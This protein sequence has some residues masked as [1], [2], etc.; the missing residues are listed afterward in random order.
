MI[1]ALITLDATATRDL[2]EF[3][4]NHVR[5]FQVFA[6]L[7]GIGTFAS[8]GFVTWTVWFWRRRR[9]RREYRAMENPGVVVFE[10]HVLR[11]RGDGDIELDVVSWGGKHTL[12]QL[13]HDTILE[14]NIEKA[15]RHK[16][17]FLCL[18]QPGQLLMMEGLVEAITGNDSSANLDSLKGRA[19]NADEV[20][21]C[22]VTWK[23][24]RAAHLVRIVILDTAWLVKLTEPT[25]IKRIKAK[26]SRYQYRVEWL[27]Q[28]V[29]RWQ[30][31][32]GKPE[33][34]ACMRIVEITSQRIK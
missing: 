21:L 16:E 6:A 7:A 12:A 23:G 4:E 25:L 26:K 30:E 13:F 27:R 33:D 9:E 2:L 20:L 22:P 28:I 5:L 29:L 11:Q 10:A 31:E 17:G 32:K 1:F 34:E 8:G 14:Q 24:L 15:S 3:A 18:E 19:A